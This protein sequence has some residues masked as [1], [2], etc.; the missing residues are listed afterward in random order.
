M[1]ARW[2]TIIPVRSQW[3]RYN[4]ARKLVSN[5]GYNLLITSYK[6]DKPGFGDSPGLWTLK[7]LYEVSWSHRF[8]Q[9]W[10]DITNGG[11]CRTSL[12]ISTN[13]GICQSVHDIP[14]LGFQHL[15]GISWFLPGPQRDEEPWPEALRKDLQNAAL[16]CGQNEDFRVPHPHNLSW[17][18][19]PSI[20]LADSVKPRW[21]N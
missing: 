16:L 14:W 20:T 21:W 15:P 8:P 7:L 2:L 12:G 10:K 3:G 6:W 5:W 11:G 9:Q 17:N 4:S 19:R 13:L 18:C 1:T